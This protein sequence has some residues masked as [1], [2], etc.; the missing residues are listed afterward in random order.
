VWRHFKAYCHHQCCEDYESVNV[1]A[2]QLATEVKAI[3]ADASIPTIEFDSVVKK[4]KR[5]ITK[6]NEL[7]KYPESKRTSSTYQ[8]G[9]SSFSA[10]FDICTCKCIDLGIR[11]KEDCKCPVDH[12][13]PV[14]EWEFWLDQKTDRRMVI[15]KITK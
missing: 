9:V 7:Q 15:G 6:G 11:E 2:K 1:T 4:I 13:V 5:L 3:Y 12:K 10:L 8:D 14:I